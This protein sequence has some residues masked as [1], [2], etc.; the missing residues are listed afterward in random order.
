[1]VEF[2]FLEVFKKYVSVSL[3]DVVSRYDVVG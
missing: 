1:M 2:L 3:R